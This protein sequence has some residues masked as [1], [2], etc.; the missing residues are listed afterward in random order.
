MIYTVE[1]RFD[2]PTREKDW[3]T[4][5]STMKLPAL[6]SVAGFHTSQ[7][8]VA[9]DGECPTYL[10]IHTIDSL[11]VL[12]GD[13]YHQKGG[14][15]FSRWQNDIS[16]WHRNLYDGIDRAPAVPVGDYLLLSSGGPDALERLGLAPH[17]IHAIA[18]EKHP[19]HRWLAQARGGQI[20]LAA[21]LPDVS[22]YAPMTPQ[23]TSP[24]RPRT[25]ETR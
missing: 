22:V 1:C 4:F 15:N 8:F 23:L 16:D 24:T 9:V 12:Y 5:Y 20:D 7:R 19:E 17:A 18:L 6:V 13:E 10:A 14:G 11:D 3:N 25:P 2:E 21:C